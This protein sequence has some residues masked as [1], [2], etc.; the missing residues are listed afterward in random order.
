MICLTRSSLMISLKS[1]PREG[2]IDSSRKTGFQQ[3]NV[4][5]T[6]RRLVPSTS[7][8]RGPT[9]RPVLTTPAN[10][11]LPQV[12]A[13]DDA[14]PRIAP[15]IA[16]PFSIGNSETNNEIT[17]RRNIRN[18]EI[19]QPAAALTA[20]TTAPAPADPATVADIPAVPEPADMVTMP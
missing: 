7:H 12:T 16:E 9:A 5:P 6:V 11:A 15:I 14:D 3:S 4:A 1:F 20:P 17:L 13:A 18:L 10:P 8:P 19:I 2:S